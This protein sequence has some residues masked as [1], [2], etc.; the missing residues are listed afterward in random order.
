MKAC[1]LWILNPADDASRGISVGN[2]GKSNHWFSGSQFFWKE[3][4]A[5]N[6]MTFLS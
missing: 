4:K 3:K 5:C 6:A 2:I 1:I